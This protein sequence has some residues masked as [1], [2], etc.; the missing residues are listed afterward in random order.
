MK[1][2]RNEVQALADMYDK[3]F[4]EVLQ[5]ANAVA[6]QFGISQQEALGYVRDGFLAGADANGEYLEG[7]K[8]YSAYFK[9]AGL[10]ASEFI[11]IST[12]A[13]KSGIYSDKAVDTIKEGN[14]RIREMTKATADALT[15]IGLNYK[16]LQTN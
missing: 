11:A 2:Y 14:L 12:Q 13:N 9:E 8:E 10:S 4:K 7:I 1:A 5:G 3:D 6:K 15:G 16:E